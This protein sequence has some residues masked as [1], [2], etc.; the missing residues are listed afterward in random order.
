MDGLLIVDKP[1]GPTSHDIVQRIRKI[2]GLR[3]VGHGG[4]LDPEATGVLLIAVG[5]GTRFFPFLSDH[6]KSYEGRIRL[7]FATDTYDAS[8]R[9]TTP[10]SRDIPPLEAVA[11]A[12]KALQGEISQ[13]PP[14]YSAKKV[15]GIPGYRLA[16]AGKE[17]DLR[18]VAVTVRAFEP[19]RYD[20]PWLDF[21]AVC[22]PG[23]YV[24]SMAHDLGR[25]L[26]C[27][28]HLHFLRRT[29]AGPFTV[30]MAVPLDRIE[31][32]VAAGRSSEVVLPLEK[33]LPDVPLA[34]VRPEALSRLTNGAP[35]LPEHLAGGGPVE[36]SLR[37]PRTLFRI[38]DTNGRLLALARTD[39]DGERLLPVLVLGRTT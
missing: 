16:R 37:T 32:A 17:F 20:P 28:A 13:A 19:V 9:A 3:R 33:L 22:S 7:G 4:T 1:A 2:F 30:N 25:A 35:L 10:E 36:K 8:G 15:A 38:V 24:R 34:C 29:S 12:M 6:E 14:P 27:G 31:E 21:R 5:Q 26:G 39:P 23:T 11:A 18:P